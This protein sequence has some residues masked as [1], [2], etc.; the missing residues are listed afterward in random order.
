MDD[1]LK[2][3]IAASRRMLYREGCDSYIAGHVSARASDGS[4]FWTTPF[5]YFDQTRPTDI[6]KFDFQLNQKEGDAAASPAVDFQSD[7]YQARP[8]VNSV[9]HTHSHWVTV[10]ATT[11]RAIEMYNTLSALF[12]EDQCRYEDDGTTSPVDGPKLLALLGNRRVAILRNH[13][14]IVAA[15][16]VEDATAMTLALELCA[17]IQVEAAMIGGTPIPFEDELVR[18]HAAYRRYFLPNMWQANLERLRQSDPEI[19]LDSIQT[20]NA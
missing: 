7:I 10:L 5:S 3:K 17:R 4:G 13:G 20:T 2:F 11:D 14:A 15:E 9:I 1:N 8:D 6:L 16:T 19:F 18:G 12:Y